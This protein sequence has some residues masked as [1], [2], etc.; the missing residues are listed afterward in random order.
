LA[1]SHRLVVAGRALCR[2]ERLE[3]HPPRAAL[4]D[5]REGEDHVVDERAP[6]RDRV[7]DVVDPFVYRDPRPERE[8]E[9][10]HDEAPEVE[11]PPVAE[12]MVRVRRPGGPTE[13]VEQQQLVAGVGHGVDRFAEHGGAAR[14]Q[15]GGELGSRHQRVSDEGG[16]DDAVGIRGRHRWSEGTMRRPPS[17]VRGQRVAV[18]CPAERVS[19]GALSLPVVRPAGLILLKLQAG[20]PKDAWDIRS[21]LDAVEQPADIVSEVE[22][23]HVAGRCAASPSALKRRPEL[24]VRPDQIRDLEARVE[25]ARVGQDPKTRPAE[26]LW[27]QAKARLGASERRTERSYTEDSQG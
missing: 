1:L 27:L 13:P 2:A 17:S 10:G 11:L 20:G 4:E 3:G 22:H 12:G 19:G 25:P 14:E 26:R 5:E 9:Q 18:A 21:R 23:A 6:D 8:D 16:D 7:Q 24:A 15:G